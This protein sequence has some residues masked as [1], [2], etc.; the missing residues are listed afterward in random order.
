MTL[1][2]VEDLSKKYNE[3]AGLASLDFSLEEGEILGLVGPNGAGKSTSIKL[4]LGLIEV[5][6]GHVWFGPDRLPIAYPERAGLDEYS[7]A[8]M[9]GADHALTLAPPDAIGGSAHPDDECI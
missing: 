4:L 2:T 8:S 7:L 6:H 3:F 5:D 1:L 9:G